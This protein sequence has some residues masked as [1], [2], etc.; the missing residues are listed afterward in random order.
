MMSN[1][2]LPTVVVGC[3]I[4]MAAV[5]AYWIASRHSKHNNE[6][7][8]DRLAEL[9][10][11]LELISSS[12]KTGGSPRHN[13]VSKSKAAKR[14]QQHLI[15]KQT[16]TMNSNVNVQPPPL[17]DDDDSIY[18]KNDQPP[19]T[20]VTK[21][22][23]D[24]ASR[25]L[26]LTRK[27]S[28]ES[29]ASGVSPNNNN[30]NTQGSTSDSTFNPRAPIPIVLISDPGQDLDDE[31]MFIMARHLVSLDLIELK[32]V[33]A[34]LHPSFARARLTRGTLDLLGLHRTPVGIGTDGGDVFGKHS[35][36]QFESTASSYIIHEDGEAARG[37][38]SG[39]RL[40][41]RLYDEADDVEYVDIY[42]DEDEEEDEEE[43]KAEGNNNRGEEEKR[44][45][46]RKLKKVVKGGLTIVITSSM[47]DIAIFVRDNPSLFAS[48]TREVIVMGG[49]KPVAA[50]GTESKDP[51]STN[52]VSSCSS[53][54][55]KSNTVWNK[56]ECE[57]D[58]AHNNTFGESKRGF[59]IF[60]SS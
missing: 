43:G 18:E 52:S 9:Q 3:S 7:I 12:S 39:H 28:M 59:R 57:P 36:D 53:Q 35:S 10:H 15:K 4:T 49:C 1:S 54:N 47:K 50:T 32:G 8:L 25:F 2:K 19:K 27:Q 45:G 44:Q 16:E 58:S 41:Q 26:H 42:E 40:L 31:M 30:V 17:S 13:K 5:T 33:I 34:N 29:R 60:R 46:S 20:I 11:R 6:N 14:K 55:E 23:G 38:E 22:N 37:L 24:R 51:A 21:L 48:K 56:V